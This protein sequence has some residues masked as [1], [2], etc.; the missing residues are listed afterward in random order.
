[1]QHFLTLFNWLEK[2]GKKHKH[3]KNKIVEM[4]EMPESE[5]IKMGFKARQSI[6]DKYNITKVAKQFFNLHAFSSFAYYYSYWFYWL[7]DL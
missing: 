4:L 7:F 5:I 1:M 6:F 2:V 3:F